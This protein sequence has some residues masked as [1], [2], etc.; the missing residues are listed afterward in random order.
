M[1]KKISLVII[2]LVCTLNFTGCTKY[3]KDSEK[4]VVKNDTTGQNIVENILCKPFAKSTIEK[5]DANKVNLEKLPSCREFKVTSGGY[6]GIWTS[7]FV[8]P[9]AWLILK[10][11]YIVKNFGL[12]IIIVTLLIRLLMM[13]FTKQA[14]LQ[15]ENL[16]KVQPEM[17]KLE[18]KYKGKTDKD[19]TMQKSQEMLMLYKKYNINPMAG[20]LFS[21]I[22]LP[23][24]M[25]FYEALYRLP[26]VF[27]GKFLF[28]ELGVTPM[29]GITLG[30]LY[31]VI[32]V[33]LVFLVTYYSFKL[34]S[35][36]SMSKEQE[37]Q[38]KMMRNVTLVMIGFASLTVSFAISCYWI[39]NSAFTIL[40]NLY[41]KKG[42]K[43]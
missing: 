43:K 1:K 2:L 21:F 40:Q 25:A 17:E 4:K 39:T 20:C 31:Y 29:V 27:E 16:K 23:L 18:K 35:G 24:F 9:L 10:I 28:Y 8:K 22:Q 3:L 34:N 38:M 12:A 30:K 6:E 33:L 36:A 15:S 19:S 5:Y 26:A 32:P 37:S 14:A 42:V 11:G 41:V 7:I 13:P